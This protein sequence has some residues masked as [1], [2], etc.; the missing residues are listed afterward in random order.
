MPGSQTK[1]KY[2]TIMTTTATSAAAT[3][4][5]SAPSL[6]G[7]RQWAEALENQLQK[8]GEHGHHVG[9]WVKKASASTG[10]AEELPSQVGSEAE[11]AWKQ[12]DRDCMQAVAFI[13]LWEGQRRI[14]NRALRDLQQQLDHA[15]D[16]YHQHEL[17]LCSSRDGEYFDDDGN[18]VSEDGTPVTGS[19]GATAHSATKLHVVPRV[20]AEDE[21]QAVS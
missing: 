1:P 14:L 18:Q 13:R 2:T 15:S 20:S 6:D 4:P 8:L 16:A 9:H 12:A 7:M 10:R 17:N 21:P 11:Q 5:S 3:K 19:T